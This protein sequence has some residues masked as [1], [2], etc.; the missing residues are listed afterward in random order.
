MSAYT[1]G[2]KSPLRRLERARAELAQ[3]LKLQDELLPPE[4][5]DEPAS[6][7][8]H[9]GTA[10]WHI[11]DAVVETDEA[12]F[13]AWR[14]AHKVKSVKAFQDQIQTQ[15]PNIGY[16]RELANGA[17]H[18]LPKQPLYQVEE[19]IVSVMPSTAAAL[20]M[21]VGPNDV[22]AEDHY[23]WKEIAGD[24]SVYGGHRPMG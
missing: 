12:D 4:R 18:H 17:K 5:G 22:Q 11:T 16:C 20:S 6:L 23:Q 1:Y 19:A 2:L 7:A 24:G 8:M 3:L 9:L 15:Y 13:V 10:I 14:A 21:V